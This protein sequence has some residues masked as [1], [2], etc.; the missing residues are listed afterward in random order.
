[1]KQQGEII[2]IG[3]DAVTVMKSPDGQQRVLI[4][5]SQPMLDGPTSSTTYRG[6]KPDKLCSQLPTS[7]RAL[8]IG[9][10]ISRSPDVRLLIMQSTQGVYVNI[11]LRHPYRD[12]ILRSIAFEMLEFAK[13][14]ELKLQNRALVY[15]LIGKTPV[16]STNP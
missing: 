12:E 5:L 1:M 11:N 2:D 8:R 13:D 3:I 10:E 14:F 15:K 4:T 7:R 16:S 9:T 6:G